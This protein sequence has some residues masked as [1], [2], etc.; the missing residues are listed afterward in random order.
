MQKSVL[1]QNNSDIT[2]VF[3]EMQ[4]QNLG[5][6]LNVIDKLYMLA[7]DIVKRGESYAVAP[8]NKKGRLCGPFYVIIYHYRIIEFSSSVAPIS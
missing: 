5:F 1:Y 6:E 2:F 3:E 4:N 7:G 8:K